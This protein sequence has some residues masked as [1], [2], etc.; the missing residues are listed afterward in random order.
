ME[1]LVDQVTN[2][3]FLRILLSS[4]QNEAN[5]ATLEA[6]TD[7]FLYHNQEDR[8]FNFCV[9]SEMAEYGNASI[10]EKIYRLW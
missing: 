7:V 8:L 3:R 4:F 1:T 6:L 2:I 9:V 5:D 10:S